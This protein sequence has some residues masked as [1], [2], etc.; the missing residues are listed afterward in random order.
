MRDIEEMQKQLEDKLDTYRY[1]HTLGVMYT[2]ASLA[3]R[4]GVELES[5]M[6]AGL[7]HDCAK[8]IPDAKKIKLCEKHGVKLSR[9]ELLNTALIHPKLGAYLA[10][11]DYGVDDEEILQAISSHT[12]GRPDMSMLEKIIY[13]ADYIEPGRK[14]IPNLKFVRKLAFENIDAALFRILEDT[15]RYLKSNHKVVDSMTEKTYYFYKELAEKENMNGTVKENGKA[16][17]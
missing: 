15:L 6:T 11:H 9:T 7:L 1:R 17:V 5:A 3:M 10:K 4:Y 16:G 2:A 8:C 13:I 14:E 12:T